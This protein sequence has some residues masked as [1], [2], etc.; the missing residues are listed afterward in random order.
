[1]RGREILVPVQ[2]SQTQHAQVHFISG[3][4]KL[5]NDLLPLSCWSEE[6]YYG[7]NVTAGKQLKSKHAKYSVTWTGDAISRYRRNA[8]LKRK[9]KTREK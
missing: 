8:L 7:M 2:P 1:M 6:T 3:V 5:H 9:G 4:K